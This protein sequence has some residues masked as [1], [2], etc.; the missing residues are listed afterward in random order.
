MAAVIDDLTLKSA[1]SLQPNFIAYANFTADSSYPAGGY[2]IATLLDDPDLLANYELL[3]V[4]VEPFYDAVGTAGY[5]FEWDLA[6]GKLIIRDAA[7]GAESSG[8]LSAIVDAKMTIF[9]Q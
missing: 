6:N 4:T 2:D 9:A 3:Y 5:L 8:D 1:K 7:D